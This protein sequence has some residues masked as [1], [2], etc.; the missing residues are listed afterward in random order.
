M[1]A[2]EV[3]SIARAVAEA[4]AA[5]ARKYAEW[6]VE[7]T[8]F[9]NADHKEI[10]NRLC[11]TGLYEHYKDENFTDFRIDPDTK[12]VEMPKPAGVI[13]ALTP[14]TNPVS[15]SST[16]RSSRCSPG[17]PSSSARTP[18]QRPAAPMLRG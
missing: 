13:F 6:A 12:M 8:G 4:A 16:R 5:S 9:G 11:S 15:R 18:T 10:K 2:P 7:E 17:T 14:S 1:P 3:L